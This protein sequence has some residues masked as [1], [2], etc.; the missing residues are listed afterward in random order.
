M[1][2]DLEHVRLEKCFF[3]WLRR[4]SACVDIK[5]C[6]FMVST[7]RWLAKPWC[8]ASR[9]G[10]AVRPAAFMNLTCR[11]EDRGFKR[12]TLLLTA[13]DRSCCLPTANKPK[14]QLCFSFISSVFSSRW[15]KL[16]GLVCSEPNIAGV[17]FC[18]ANFPLKQ[19]SDYKCVMISVSS[20]IHLY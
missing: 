11:S 6:A 5:A 13:D 16:W 18:P 10:R 15:T 20:V 1:P 3:R 17:F 2:R 7:W 8:F 4:K 9:S 19:F 14:R 12:S